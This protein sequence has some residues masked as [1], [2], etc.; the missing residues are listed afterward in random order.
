MMK[1]SK[2]PGISRAGL[3]KEVYTGGNLSFETG[4]KIVGA[5]GMRLSARAD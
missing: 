5:C 3:Y 2:E 1:L 4:T